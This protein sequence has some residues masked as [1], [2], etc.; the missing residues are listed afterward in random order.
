MRTFGKQQQRDDAPDQNSTQDQEDCSL[1]IPKAFI[2]PR[3]VKGKPI[4][5]AYQMLPSKLASDANQLNRLAALASVCVT[6]APTRDQ[7]NCHQFSDEQCPGIDCP[8]CHYSIRLH[9]RQALDDLDRLEADGDDLSDEADNVL[10]VVGAVGVVGDAAAFVGADL[11]LVNDPFEG[12]TVLAAPEPRFARDQPTIPPLPFRRGEGWGEGSVLAPGFR[13][14]KRVKMSA[15]SLPASGAPGEGWEEGHK[16]EHVVMKSPIYCTDRQLS[17]I[18]EFPRLRI[19]RRNRILPG[20]SKRNDEH[21][22]SSCYYRRG[23][24]NRLFPPV[25]H[26]R[27]RNVRV[28]PTLDSPLA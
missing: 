22:H 23:R 18:T 27:R 3:F 6:R 13:G 21:A 14:A 1:H 17:C 7:E 25:S 2:C 28:A 19:F 4:W 15:G 5:P 11:V 20:T 9:W 8:R 12:G 24:P 16:P 26:R 10:G